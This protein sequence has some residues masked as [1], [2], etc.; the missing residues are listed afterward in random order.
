MAGQYL[1]HF[2]QPIV[3]SSC[4]VGQSRCPNNG[5]EEGNGRGQAMIEHDISLLRPSVAVN[6]IVSHAANDADVATAARLAAL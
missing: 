3:L 5:N 1:P 4:Q 6:R 2:A